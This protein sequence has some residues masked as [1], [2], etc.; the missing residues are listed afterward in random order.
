[1]TRIREGPEGANSL[2]QAIAGAV[3][4]RS[5]TDEANAPH[6]REVLGG[7]SSVTAPGPSS[8]LRAEK[9]SMRAGI[10]WG[11]IVGAA[12]AATPLALWWLDAATGYAVG[13]AVIAF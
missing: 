7:R 8:P 3:A 4:V 6:R 2:V 1:M 11:I 10:A 9:R 5:R 13:L 12:Q